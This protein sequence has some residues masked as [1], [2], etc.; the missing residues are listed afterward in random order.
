MSAAL[1]IR[2]DTTEYAPYYEKYVSLV[3]ET[4]IIGA[5]ESQLEETLNLIRGLS[6]EQAMHRYAPDKW[7]IKEVIGHIIDGE[8]I[9]AYRALRF[10]RNDKQKL[11]GFDQDDFMQYADF[12]SR[13]MAD[14]AEEF[15]LSRRAN[16]LMF[17]SF[18]EEVWTRRGIASEAEVSVRG[19]AYIMAGH[20]RHHVRILKERYLS[21]S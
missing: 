8:R 17:K 6:E 7:S 1:A 20:E 14:L 9:F 3:S 2:P 4:N 5:L 15:E 13:S 16:I 18:S 12:D 10:S 19:L 11:P 21:E